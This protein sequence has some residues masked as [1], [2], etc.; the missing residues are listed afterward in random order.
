MPPSARV[1]QAHADSRTSVKDSNTGRRSRSRE[2]RGNVEHLSD[3]RRDSR[4][5][6]NG[7]GGSEGGGKG[8]NVRRG[9]D[10]DRERY[11]ETYKRPPIRRS[12]D[13]SVER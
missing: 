1:D 2:R 10:R 3:D 6:R 8:L 9:G 4:Q 13:R 5:D 11:D 12:A 7:G